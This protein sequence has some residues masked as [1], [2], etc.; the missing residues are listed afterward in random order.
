MV[1]SSQ[2]L[3]I[4]SVHTTFSPSFVFHFQTYYQHMLID[5]RSKTLFCFAPKV[6]CTNLKLLFFISQGL[7][8]ESELQQKNMAIVNQ[9]LEPVM[10]KHSFM[11][12]NDAQREYSL[13]NYF[14]FI[15][16]RNPL[17]RLVSGYRSKVQQY[18]LIGTMPDT[19]HYNWLREEVYKF[20]HAEEYEA[21]LEAG[22]KTEVQISFPDFIDYWLS[23]PESVRYEQHFRPIAELCHPCRTRF[24]FYGNFKFFEE[25]AAV[26]KL[27]LHAKDEYLRL[28]YYNAATETSYLLSEYYEQLSEKQKWLVF[29][30]FLPE[31]DFFYRIFPEELNTHKQILKI[32]EDVPSW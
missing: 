31:L 26:L 13:K 1:G 10:F 8:N 9:G 29:Y 16:Y 5:E 21:W 22:S 30:R 6:G 27:R 28:G 32:L 15:M 3:R 25:D 12:R 11:N 18:P 19:P 17:E 24:D 20:K 7:I 4:K 23:N 14:K 2:L